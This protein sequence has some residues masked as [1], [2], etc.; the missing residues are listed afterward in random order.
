MGVVDDAGVGTVGAASDETEVT[1]RGTELLVVLG[2]ESC[3]TTAELN[4]GGLV[5]AVLTTSAPLEPVARGWFVPGLSG[6]RSGVASRE[7]RRTTPF[8]H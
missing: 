3:D 6:S 1:E 8:V 5:A 4:L 7:V 2:A